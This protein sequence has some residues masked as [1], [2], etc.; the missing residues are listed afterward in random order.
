[1]V[2]GQC[3]DHY[4]VIIISAWMEGNTTEI[5]FVRSLRTF[6][7]GSDDSHAD[8]DADTDADADSDAAD[9][10]EDLAGLLMTQR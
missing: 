1:M 2:F 8:A 3:C 9:A 10:D 4:T 7:A 5:K 6:L